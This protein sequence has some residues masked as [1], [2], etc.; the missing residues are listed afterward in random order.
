MTPQ[1]PQQEQPSA[2]T[3]TATTATSPL[4]NH[5]HHPSKTSP[6]PPGIYAPTQA[7]FHTTS[8]TTL[9][10]PTTAQHAL[11]LAR[12]GITGLVTNGSNG[13]AAHL[14]PTERATIT[15]TTRAALDGAGY[16]HVP[17]LSGASHAS[18]EGTVELVKQAREAGAGGVL[19]LVPSAFGWAM[20]G[21]GVVERFFEGVVK[22]GGE[23]VQVVVYNYPAAAGGLDLDSDLLGRLAEVGVA[24]VK[25][26]CGNVGKLARVVGEREMQGD[27]RFR[28]F[29]G[30]A[31]AIVPALAVGGHGGIVG[32][33]NV[34]PRA[35]VQV[36]KLF[37]E[38]RWEEARVAQQRLARADWAM[39]KR[40]IPGFKSVL[41]KYH[42]YGG[43]PRLPVQPLSQEEE[44]KLFAEV[45]EMM[46]FEAGLEDF[47]KPSQ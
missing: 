18:L 11:R 1:Q 21:G 22:E 33:A 31:D 2:P 34:F 3:A 4:P 41:Q 42:G 25:F 8:P 36:Y 7:F 30:V 26:T 28:C 13:E 16:A 39:T 47:G 35:C 17:V 23:G 20:K 14:T 29:S 10:L 37:E 32:A 44:E 46:A 24:G 15:R 45:E 40:A 38:G 43:I 6:L 19:V 5:H 12:A 27:G 9:D